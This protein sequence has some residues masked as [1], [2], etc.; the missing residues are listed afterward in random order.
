MIV[1]PV[2]F[3]HTLIDIKII[4]KN[5]DFIELITKLLQKHIKGAKTSSCLMS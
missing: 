5:K 2:R 4:K 1:M 3:M